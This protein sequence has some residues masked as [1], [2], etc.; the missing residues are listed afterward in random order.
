MGIDPDLKKLG[1]YGSSVCW[2]KAIHG[3]F[4]AIKYFRFEMAK[5]L[6]RNW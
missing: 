3:D 4:S 6:E 1:A 5:I 2:A